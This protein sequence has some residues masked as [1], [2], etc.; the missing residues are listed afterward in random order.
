VFEPG[1]V[2]LAKIVGTLVLAITT[3]PLLF[4]LSPGIEKGEPKPDDGHDHH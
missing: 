2:T 4:L 3:I 1:Y